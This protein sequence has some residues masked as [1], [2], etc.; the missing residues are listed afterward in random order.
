MDIDMDMDMDERHTRQRYKDDFANYAECCLKMRPKSGRNT[1]LKLNPV[2]KQILATAEAQRAR[3]GQVRILVLKARQPGVST[4]VEAKFYWKTTHNRGYRAFI[5]THKDEATENLFQMAK[6]FHAN[7]PK[8]LQP[9]TSASNAKELKFGHL[10]SSYRVGTAKAEGAG[11]SDTI[12][13]FHGSEVAH[14][15]NAEKHAAGAL[16]AVPGVDDTEIWLESTANGASGLFY[17]MCVKAE[18][19]EGDYELIFI[20]WFEHL[21][22][23]KKPPK[24]WEPG[25][26]WRDYQARYTIGDAQLCWAVAKNAELAGS[27]G[28]AFDRPCWLFCQ[29]YPADVRQAFQTSGTNSFI[30][31]ES[32]ATAQSASFAAPDKS[33]PLVFGADIAHGGGDMTHIIDRCG[34]HMGHTVNLSLDEAD[35]M[36]IAGHLAGLIQ[37]YKPDMV[38][39]DITGGYGAGVV[40]RLREQGFACLRGIN[41][42]AKAQ[43]ADL[44]ANKRAEMWANLRNW[45]R[46]GAD[47]VVDNVLARHIS[48]PSAK[49]DS[50]GRLLIEKKDNIRKRL[51]LSPDRGDAAALTFAEPVRRKDFAGGAPERTQF[52][53]Y[54]MGF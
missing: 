20:P 34:R 13:L 14:W 28:D 24:G 7:C 3:T 42:A 43:R 25:A 31:P 39:V 5:L 30:G 37:R 54:L 1:L 8:L 16:Q 38:F 47:M 23:T 21:E 53:Y 9:K 36:T 27:T 11:R 52:D 44:Y 35:E 17:N 48:A 50:S 4:Y 49:P 41:F 29:E 33:V 45:L 10:D 40:V 18:A 6:R 22:Y 15:P 32:I 46:G 2:Q 12:Q 51:S 26:I 19:G